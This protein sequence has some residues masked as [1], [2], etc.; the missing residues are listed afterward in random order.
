MAT[1]LCQ[2]GRAPVLFFTGT[3]F[4]LP[5]EEFALRLSADL[6]C[7]ILAKRVPSRKVPPVES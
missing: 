7:R 6:Y 5:I 4:L 2:N 3:V 1:S